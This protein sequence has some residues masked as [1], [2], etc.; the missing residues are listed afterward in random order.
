MA[1]SK[2]III[3]HVPALNKNEN[4]LFVLIREVKAQLK[5]DPTYDDIAGFLFCSPSAINSYFSGSR[6]LPED[7]AFHIAMMIAFGL[8]N[9]FEVVYPDGQ[10]KTPSGVK[11]KIIRKFQA[12]PLPPKPQEYVQISLF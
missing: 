6:K 4:P 8:D 5:I 11:P 2:H 1:K 12:T 3:P 9:L 10:R 7:K